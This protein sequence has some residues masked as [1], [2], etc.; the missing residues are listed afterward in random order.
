MAGFDIKTAVKMSHKLKS[1]IT[2]L[3]IIGLAL[4]IIVSFVFYLSKSAIKKQSQQNIKKTHETA[5]DT[6][7]IKEFINKCLDKLAKDALVLLGKQGGYIYTS[8]GGTLID[9]SDTDEGLFFIKHDNLKVAYNI[10]PP[11]FAV[12]H[13]SSDIPD[14]PWTTFPYK[15]DASN[16]ET[17]EGFFGISNLPPLNP[18]GGPN[19]IQSQIEAFIDN[20]IAACADFNLFKS[21]GYDIHIGKSKTH[22]TIGNADFRIK[23]EMPTKIENIVSK[24]T[25]EIKEFSADMQVNLLNSYFFAKYLIENDVKNIKF[26]ISTAGYNAATSIQLIKN[27]FS[28]GSRKIK[29]DLV[30]LTDE[31]SLIY[32]KPLK[33]TFAIRNRAPALYYIRPNVFSF[34]EGY[35]INETDILKNNPLAAG[36]PDDDALTFKI[37]STEFGNQAASFPIKLVLPHMKFRIE[38]NDGQLSDYQVITVNKI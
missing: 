1:Q 15:S 31:S 2:M 38:V 19:S 3:M 23:S 12:A 4:F 34:P 30:I 20:N 36:D 9:Y 25:S 33:Y 16:E 18:S 10:L 8:Q 6:Q 11:K 5:I 27:V 13:Y 7:P 14:Y 21:Q 24:E 28:D 26:N 32:G 37:Y 22:V 29:A 35:L 17:F